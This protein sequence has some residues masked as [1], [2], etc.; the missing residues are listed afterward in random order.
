MLFVTFKASN[1]VGIVR[2]DFTNLAGAV[3]AL[4]ISSD[5]PNWLHTLSDYPVEEVIATEDKNI[6]LQH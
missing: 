1:Q 6:L 2:V 4:D 3:H 5:S